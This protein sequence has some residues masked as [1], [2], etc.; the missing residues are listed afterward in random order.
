MLVQLPVSAFRRL[1]LATQNH[2]SQ[3]RGAV[4][5]VPRAIT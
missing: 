5:A 1:H 4:L 3:L 2:G